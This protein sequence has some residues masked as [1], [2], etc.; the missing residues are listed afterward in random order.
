MCLMKLNCERKKVETC[1]MIGLS[2]LI[3]D[4]I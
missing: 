4:K 3:V 1:C 2:T